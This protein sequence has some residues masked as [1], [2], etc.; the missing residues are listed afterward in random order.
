MWNG[1]YQG[2]PRVRTYR[3]AR[4]VGF[5]SGRVSQLLSVSQTSAVEPASTFGPLLPAYVCRAPWQCRGSSAPHLGVVASFITHHT[6]SRPLCP[7]LSRALAARCAFPFSWFG[8]NMTTT[9]TAVYMYT[10]EVHT[11]AVVFD[12]SGGTASSV[13]FNWRL[14]RSKRS[15]YRTYLSS[16]TSP[17]PVPKT[18]TL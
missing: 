6:T 1:S 3:T 11:T 8:P 17:T 9:T 13:A 7:K 5:T 2:L 12:A 16:F 10:L 18:R 4:R 14:G 15:T